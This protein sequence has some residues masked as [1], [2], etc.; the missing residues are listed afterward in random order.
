MAT[1]G[2]ASSMPSVP[3]APGSGKQ[4]GHRFLGAADRASPTQGKIT[5]IFVQAQRRM[6]SH[7]DSSVHAV[8][9]VASGSARGQ[10]RL[11]DRHPETSPNTRE[12][13]RE[14]DVCMQDMKGPE[15]QPQSIRQVRGRGG[16]RGL[17]HGHVR[18]RGRGRCSGSGSASAN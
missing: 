14:G 7:Q 8:G 4:A 15:P 9:R 11:V 13:D 1:S 16:S 18:G 12:Y 2:P 10:Q 6:N 3:Q 17:A 5:G